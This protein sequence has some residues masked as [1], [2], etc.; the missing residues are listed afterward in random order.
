MTPNVNY[1]ELIEDYCQDQLDAA[2]KAEFESE[3]G[4]D[5]NLRKE[6][7]LRQQLCFCIP[8]PCQISWRL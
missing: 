5:A 4:L 7:K 1:F 2:T 3:L 8:L 6:V